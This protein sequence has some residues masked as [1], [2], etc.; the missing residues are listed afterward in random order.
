MLEALSARLRR[1]RIVCG[2][3][4]RITGDSVLRTGGTLGNAVLLDPPYKVGNQQ[5]EAGGTG[6]CVWDEAA[7]WALDAV[8]REP[9]LKVALCGYEGHWAP[10]DEWSTF[11]WKAHGGF[12]NQASDPGR[13]NASREVVWF[14]PA[15]LPGSAAEESQGAA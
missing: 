1:T 7:A 10:P 2:D 5:Y 3:W 9:R 8:A 11:S 4:R 14:S 6:S 15:C 13:A 12:G